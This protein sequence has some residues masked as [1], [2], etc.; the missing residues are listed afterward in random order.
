MFKLL[1]AASLSMATI[2]DA[3]AAPAH[4]KGYMIAE[5]AVTNPVA[6]EEYKT[7]VAPMI[8]KF[9]GRYLTRGGKS[10]ALEGAAPGGR[11]IILEF[12]SYA[13]AKAFYD[14]PEYRAI[15]HHRTDNATSRVTV[16]EGLAP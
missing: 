12:P 11:V 9:G 15:L 4:A 8:T 13:E 14:S 6:Y 10:E 1:A 7:L 2:A 16:I 3:A 5:I